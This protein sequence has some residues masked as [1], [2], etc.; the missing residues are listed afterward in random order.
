MSELL[1]ELAEGIDIPCQL[2]IPEKPPE[3]LDKAKFE[4][5]R[6]FFIRNPLSVLMSNFR[7]LVLGL[8]V[9]N[10]CDVLVLTEKSETKKKAFG[11]YLETGYFMNKW[12][13]KSRP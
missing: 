5:G 11:R 10:L 12:L 9:V 2:K 4:R 7:N 3:W 8:S 13:M 1:K 6:E